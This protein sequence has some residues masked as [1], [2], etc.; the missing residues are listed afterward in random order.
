MTHTHGA[1]QPG[2]SHDC[3]EDPSESVSIIGLLSPP[4]QE[5]HNSTTSVWPN[6]SAWSRWPPLPTRLSFSATAKPKYSFKHRSISQLIDT[7]SDKNKTKKMMLRTRAAIRA[8]LTLLLY[9]LRRSN[10]R[11]QVQPVSSWSWTSA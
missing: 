10:P 11:L 2:R 6:G 3:G 7:H 5:N 1:T 4:Q 8:A 9:Y